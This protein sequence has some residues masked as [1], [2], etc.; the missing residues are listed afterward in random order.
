MWAEFKHTLRRL[1]WQVVGWGIGLALYGVFMARFYDSIQGNEFLDDLLASYPPELMAFFGD[2]ANIATPTGYLDTYFF[3]YMPLIIGIFSIGVGAGLLV[4]DEEKGILDLVMAQPV[5]RTALFFGRLAGYTAATILILLI[6]WLSWVFPA[7]NTS[8]DLTPLE[9][10]IPFLPLFA[11]L[12]MFGALALLL[13][14][15]LPSARAASFL[16][17]ALLVANW[18]LLGLANLNQDLRNLS[19]F[20]PLHFFQGGKAID[21]MN[22]TWFGGLLGISA[23]FCLLA[24]LLFRRRDI[25]VGGE[26]SWGLPALRRAE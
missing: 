25:R 3:W 20:T 21:G 19:R 1:R 18:L 4:G 8:L 10:L 23:V 13:S 15:L 2:I 6:S 14:M 16:T 26:R 5:S 7:A 22:W 9:F 12:L 11:I 24:W 17:G